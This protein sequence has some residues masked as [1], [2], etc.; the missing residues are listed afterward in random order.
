MEEEDTIRLRS[1]NAA[2][3]QANDFL[4]SK[5]ELLEEKNAGLLS[6]IAILRSQTRTIPEEGNDG[7]QL[8]AA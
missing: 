7:Q 2:L 1:E 5:V 3:R 8:R 6:E 4:H